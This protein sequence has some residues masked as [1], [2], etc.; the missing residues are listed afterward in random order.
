[1]YMKKYA[2]AD[3][4][5]AKIRNPENMNPEQL[6]K[7]IAPLKLK[8]DKGIPRTQNYLLIR[9]CWWIHV[10]KRE[11]I[12]IDDEEQ[13]LN[14]DKSTDCADKSISDDAADELISTAI[15]GGNLTDFLMML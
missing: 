12:V 11:R 3:A 9:Y 13:N 1:M 5:L 10:E 14:A 6:R 2:T 4:V 7:V 8:Q 15:N